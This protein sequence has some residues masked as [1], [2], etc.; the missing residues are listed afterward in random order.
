MRARTVAPFLR[1]QR[2][3]SSSMSNYKARFL[4]D[5]RDQLSELEPE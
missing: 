1:C 5:E 3:S 4:L 2:R